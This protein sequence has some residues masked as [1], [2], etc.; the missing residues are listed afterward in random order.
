MLEVIL[1]SAKDDIITLV[2]K[3]SYR[4]KILF[5]AWNIEDI[6]EMK[7]IAWLPLKIDSTNSSSY[8][9]RFNKMMILVKIKHLH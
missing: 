1:T 8:M 3:G 4:N 5:K 7:R 6:Y 9:L 2:L